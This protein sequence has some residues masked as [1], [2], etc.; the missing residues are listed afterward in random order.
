LIDKKTGQVIPQ[1]PSEEKG[2]TE[3]ELKRLSDFI[4]TLD[5]DKLG[6]EEKGNEDS[7]Q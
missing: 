7:D 6:E 1:Q 5:I 4:D 2:M 3:A